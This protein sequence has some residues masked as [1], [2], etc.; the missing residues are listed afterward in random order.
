MYQRLTVKRS[1]Q[2][3]VEPGFSANATDSVGDLSEKVVSLVALAGKNQ[4]DDFVHFLVDGKVEGIQS[5]VA[6]G[7]TVKKVSLDKLCFGVG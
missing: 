1:V 7:N 4:M 3:N 6:A 2:S 5:E